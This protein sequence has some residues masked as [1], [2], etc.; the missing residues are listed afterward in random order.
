[1]SA[2]LTY[3]ELEQ[4]VS[5]LKKENVSLHNQYIA[6]IDNSMDAVLLT[7]PG[8]GVFFANQAACNLFQ[9][10]KQELLNGGRKAVV[11]L[12]DSRLPIAL[13]ERERT[14]QFIGE[15]NFKK[16][17]GTIFLGEVSSSIYKDVDG[18]TRSSMVIRDLTNRKKEEDAL[19]KSKLWLQNTLDSLEETVLVVTPD[20]K[21]LDIND[22]GKKMFGYSKEE[23]SGLSTEILHVDHEHYVEFGNCIREA[24]ATGEKANFE[25]EAKRKNGQIFPTE[26]TVTLLKDPTGTSV[27]IVSVVRD[28]SE[29][30]RAEEALQAS[31][32]RH[33]M[34][35]EHMSSG[36]AV[37]ETKDDGGTFV[38]KDVNPAAERISKI[39]KEKTVGRE[40]LALFPKMDQFGLVD[41]LRRVWKTGQNERLHAGYY[42]DDL[43]QGWRDNRIYKL[44]SGAVVAIYDDVTEQKEAERKLEESEKRLRTVLETVALVAIM[45]DS[46]G[47]LIFCNDFFLN[48]TGW[49]RE[50]VLGKDWFDIFVPV[51]IRDDLKRSIFLKALHSG[52]FPEHYENEIV[53]SRGERRL[54]AWNN[55][56]FFN[57][58]GEATEA[59][60]IGED[61][62]DRRKSEERLRQVQKMEAIATLA[63]GIAHDYNNLLAVIMGNLSLAQEETDPHSVM[64]E[65]LHEIEQASF[66]ARDLTDQFLTLSRGGHPR[67]ELGTIEGLLRE[68]RGQVQAHEHIEYSFSIEDDLWFVEHDSK[69]LQDAVTN[70]LK[71]A[72]EAM[73]QGG[74]ITV[75]AQNQIIDNKE[76]DPSL[77]LNEGRYVRISIKDEGP[78]IPEEHMG[79]VFDPYFSTKAR[80]AQKGMGLGLTTAYAAVE[81]HG[82]HITL[83]STTG[84]GTTVD[85]YLPAAEKKVEKPIAE[86]ASADTAP[87]I[88]SGQRPTKKILVMDDEESLRN[89]AQKM[90]ER[91]EY[92]VEVVKDGLEALEKYKRYMDSGKPFDAVILDLT[93]KGGMGG[94]QTI[95][96]LLKID[97][98]VKAI[99]SSGYYNDPVMTEFDKYGFK[100]AMAKP[101]QKVDL[102]NVLKTLL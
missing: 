29:R 34:M 56:V 91:L 76:K 11:D 41:A 68:V 14:G 101:Y 23:I 24:F 95:Q 13:E 38:F 10:T 89:L 51:D 21:I 7:E 44:P 72:V 97:P 2:K 92:E 93:I 87:L 54:I 64:A 70:V 53:T 1:M 15:I 62:T 30:K 63:G 43:R 31:E 100:G 77:P 99:V 59:A 28:I 86:Q 26:H 94:E 33:R 73:P 67:K 88:G 37:Y 12:G 36:V 61:I 9:M 52:E 5:D 82:G 57:E 22:G 48:M 18:Q 66:K 46:K 50:E 27:G 78:G 3:E 60:S 58:K 85:I 32:K 39:K 74:T 102:E 69:L 8:G 65:L 20:R 6:I 25:F 47:Q 79:K 98:D 75:Q 17:D 55:T 49:T 81:K 80:G 19:L 16:K 96:E 42:R 4:H 40:L 35:I 45:L 84:V 90:L 83:S 71:N